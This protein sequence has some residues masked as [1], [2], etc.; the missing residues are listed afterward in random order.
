[1]LVETG[2]NHPSLYPI[3]IF[4]PTSPFVCK[5][6][7]S[8]WREA[9][10]IVMGGMEGVCVDPG[11]REPSWKPGGPARREGEKA[12]SWPQTVEEDRRSGMAQD[13]GDGLVTS[14]RDVYAQSECYVHCKIIS[15]LSTITRIVFYCIICFRKINHLVANTIYIHPLMYGKL[16]RA[17]S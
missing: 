8:D 14:P 6:K 17:Q 9:F 1:M 13:T 7:L 5:P 4:R 2:Q 15:I 16:C 11:E 10:I 12:G 3:L